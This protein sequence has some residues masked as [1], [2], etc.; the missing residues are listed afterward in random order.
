[1]H[2]AYT[3]A[4]ALYPLAPALA[5]AILI[6]AIAPLLPSETHQLR[7]ITAH[8]SRDALRELAEERPS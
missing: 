8:A 4:D 2:P 3:R 5:T 7:E 6:E 1:E